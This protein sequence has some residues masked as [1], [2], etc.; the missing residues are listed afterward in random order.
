MNSL[1]NRLA[2]ILILAIVSVVALATLAASRALTPPQ[3]ER[4]LGPIA[5]QLTI[6][7]RLARENRGAALSAG[8]DLRA[9]PAVGDQRSRLSQH[10]TE[11][12]RAKGLATTAIVTRTEN[13]PALIASIDLGAQGWL[14][15]AFPDLR[16]P[17]GGWKIFA[18][19]L[20][21]ITL[22]AGV[23]S[24]YAAMRVTGPLRLLEGAAQRIGADGTL[25]LLPETGPA[26]TRATARALNQL[27]ARLTSAMDSRMRLVAAAGHDL[28]TPMTRMR[29]R[30]EFIEDDEERAK[31]LSDLEELDTI[32]DSAIR[33]VRE[34]VNRDRQEPVRLD[35]LLRE[36]AE[37][38][39]SLSQKVS[40]TSLA[41]VRVEAG[42]LALKRA[43]RNLI[44]NAATHGG[45]ATI[46]LEDAGGAARLVISDAGPGIPEAL[47]EQVFEPFFRVD[48][49]RRKTVPGAGLGLAIAKEIIERFGGSIAISNRTPQGLN[50]IVTLPLA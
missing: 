15:S 45:G 29:L 6:L 18:G 1:R 46:L 37:E 27:S 5:E 19:W 16:P 22:G 40:V 42:P 10:L 43:L 31:W 12:L 23:V 20:V 36:I 7:A 3:P 21:L 39:A 26:E 28:R 14:V 38:L 17:P 48:I 33:L 24:I 25:P 41:P 49:A 2:A 9:E 47:I 30:A 44:A 50:Q 8:L 11:Q 4:A 13:P 35:H 34:E 32:A